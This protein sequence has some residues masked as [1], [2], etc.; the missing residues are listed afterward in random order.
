ME[1]LHGREEED[2]EEEVSCKEDDG[3][4]EDVFPQE[5]VAQRA[6]RSFTRD[7]S[8]NPAGPFFHV[9]RGVSDAVAR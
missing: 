1:G 4:E 3:E 9:S 2:R 5:E 6:L 8:A 7:G